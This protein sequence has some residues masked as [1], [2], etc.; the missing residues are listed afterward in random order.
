M[1]VAKRAEQDEENER[2]QYALLRRPDDS[3][4]VW[5]AGRGSL[6]G[7]HAVLPRCCDQTAPAMIR[8]LTTSAAASGTP[9]ASSV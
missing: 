4:S 3:A 5:Q 9:L 6:S 8:P 1:I 2:D 7:A